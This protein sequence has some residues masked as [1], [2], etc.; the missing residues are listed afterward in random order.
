[1]IIKG[2]EFSDDERYRYSLWRIW[3]ESGRKVL[4][5]C[6]NPSTADDVKNDP[7][8]KRCEGFARHWGY[9]GFYMANLFGYRCTNPLLLRAVADPVGEENDLTL[10][11]LSRYECD[12]VVAAWGN[13]GE[14]LG[15]SHRVMEILWKSSI[16]GCGAPQCFG[17]NR[18]GE[19]KHLLYLRKDAGLIIIDRPQVV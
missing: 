7:T 10:R 5:V 3:R 4:F 14:Y 6:L 16:N 18:S 1:M 8:I 12:L 11:K 2:A 9:G 15:R 17:F 19:P 13:H